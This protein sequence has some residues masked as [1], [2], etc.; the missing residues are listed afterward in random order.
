MQR[1]VERAVYHGDNADNEPSWSNTFAREM[2]WPIY[3]KAALWKC[4]F[5]GKVVTENGHW[6]C[7]VTAIK[8]LIN[9]TDMKY[10]DTR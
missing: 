4:L 8:V 1:T 6:F 2:L 10:I 7:Y 9:Q 5:M 3:F